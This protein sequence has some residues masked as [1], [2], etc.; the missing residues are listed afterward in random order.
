MHPQVLW[1]IPVLR[2]K[3]SVQAVFRLL[4]ILEI[5]VVFSQKIRYNKDVLVADTWRGAFS[6]QKWRMYVAKE[7]DVIK[8]VCESF[9]SGMYVVIL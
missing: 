3:V 4:I 6:V 2:R 1:D 5:Q 7:T 9:V 8:V